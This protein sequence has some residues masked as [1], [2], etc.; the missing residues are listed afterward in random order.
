MSSMGSRVF[1]PSCLF[2]LVFFLE[3]FPRLQLRVLR[4]ACRRVNCS[5]KM[6][7]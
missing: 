4:V 3:K 2:S 6:F 5:V 1:F 7:N